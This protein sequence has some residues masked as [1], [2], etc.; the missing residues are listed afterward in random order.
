MKNI[1]I[2]WEIIIFTTKQLSKDIKSLAILLLMPFILIAILGVSL[3]GMFN[4]SGFSF[5]QVQLG[6]VDE[7]RSVNSQLFIDNAFNNIEIEKIVTAKVYSNEEAE[8]KF[9]NEEIDGILYLHAGYGENYLAGIPDEIVLKMNPKKSTQTEIIKMV[10]NQYHIIGHMV[11]DVYNSEDPETNIPTLN[12]FLV[13][14]TLVT[15]VDSVGENEEYVNAFQ[16]Y[17]IGMGVMFALFTV[18]TGVGFVI[19]ESQQNTLKRIR[20]MPFSTSLFYIGKSLAFM[21]III[22]QLVILFLANHL[23]FGVNFGGEPLLILLSIFA[24]SFALMGLMIL[25]MGWINNQNTLNVFYSVGV[26]VLAALGG[27]MF[28][29]TMFPA[30]FET[31]SHFLPNRHALDAFFSVILGQSSEMMNSVIFLIIFGIVSTAVGIIWQLFGK[32]EGTA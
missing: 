18:F 23:I 20:M 13:E 22:L 28:P 3:S 27:S 30:F 2:I 26:P 21:I 24:Y 1:K 12:S 29:V 19:D 7:D 8:E 15:E 17:T 10:T 31:L 32:K 25:L 16:Y 6:I 14:Q 11:L 9:D 4:D 5:E